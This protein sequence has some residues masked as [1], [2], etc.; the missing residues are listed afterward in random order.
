MSRASA[1]TAPALHFVRLRPYDA[2]AATFP[3]SHVR[4]LECAH[5]KYGDRMLAPVSPIASVHVPASLA[6][7]VRVA[8]TYKPRSLREMITVLG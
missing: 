6:V 7:A 8:F 3:R 4:S 5:P 2:E 1:P